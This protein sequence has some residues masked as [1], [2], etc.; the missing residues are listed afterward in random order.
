MAGKKEQLI[1]GKTKVQN[2]Q[3]MKGIWKEE[4]SMEMKEKRRY[5]TTINQ[6]IKRGR[7]QRYNQGFWRVKVLQLQIER[8]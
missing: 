2:H 1:Q 4:I 3:C 5:G 7:Q 8:I 6:D